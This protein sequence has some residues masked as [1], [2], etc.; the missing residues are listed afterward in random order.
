MKARTGR[1]P[2]LPNDHDP[3]STL[4]VRLS[5]ADKSLLVAMAE[6]YGMTMTEYI[7]TLVRRDSSDATKAD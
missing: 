4:T 3:Y 5:A 7:V 1:P 6:G 2:K